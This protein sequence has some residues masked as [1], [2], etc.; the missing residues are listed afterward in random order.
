MKLN[1]GLVWLLEIEFLFGGR[2]ITRRCGKIIKLATGPGQA[3]PVKHS[4][5]YRV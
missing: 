2:K 5:G 4:N 1:L 3:L